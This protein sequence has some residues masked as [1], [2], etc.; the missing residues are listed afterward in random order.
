MPKHRLVISARK[1]LSTHR[2]DN[3]IP[4][5]G[6][7]PAS[8]EYNTVISGKF[9]ISSAVLGIYG[10]NIGKAKSGVRSLNTNNKIAFNPVRTV[11]LNL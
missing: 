2:V 5:P 1:S 7:I 3:D 11:D 4:F 8:P 6:P 9:I 10:E